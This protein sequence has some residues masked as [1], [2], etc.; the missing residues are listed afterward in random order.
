[1]DSTTG[2]SEW[3]YE[4]VI[5][6][7]ENS[8]DTI[9]MNYVTH[10]SNETENNTWIEYPDETTPLL[11]HFMFANN[12]TRDFTYD[13]KTHNYKTD[14]VN[15][16]YGRADFTD[17]VSG[18]NVNTSTQAQSADPKHTGESQYFYNSA[19]IWSPQHG[20]KIN[21]NVSVTIHTTPLDVIIEG[22]RT[23]GD[24]GNT[25]GYYVVVPYQLPLYDA[26]G[27]EKRD[28]E[29][30]IL[31]GDP[32]WAYYKVVQDGVSTSATPYTLMDANDWKYG[33]KDYRTGKDAE[34]NVIPKEGDLKALCDAKATYM[35]TYKG[36]AGLEAT[37][38]NEA[39]QTVIQALRV[40]KEDPTKDNAIVYTSGGTALT[41][42]ITKN[43]TSVPAKYPRGDQSLEA[44]TYNVVGIAYDDKGMITN[45]NTANIGGIDNDHNNYKI[46]YAGG[47]TVNKADLFYT[48]D[49]TKVY[50]DANGSGTNVYKL[51]GTDANSENTSVTGYLKSFDSGKLTVDTNNVITAGTGVT[52]NGL[53][54]TGPMTMS[55]TVPE[56]TYNI[57]QNGEQAIT[58]A[59][60]SDSYYQ[61]LVNPAD[62]TLKTY[63]VTKFANG[64][65]SIAAANNANATYINNNYNMVW[66]SNDS[67]A[68]TDAARTTTSSTGAVGGATILKSG[69]GTGYAGAG[70]AITA[71]ASSEL[72]TP[73]EL[74]VTVT[75]TRKYGDLMVKDVYNTGAT[76]VF[77]IT[78]AGTTAT[79]SG[80][81]AGDTINGI[82]DATKMNPIIDGIEALTG[83]HP[84]DQINEATHVGTYN[85]I[86][87]TVQTAS[88]IDVATQNT[89]TKHFDILNTN[90]Y[91]Y[92]I[93]NGAHAETITPETVTVTTTGER[94]YGDANTT[95]TNLTFTAPTLET[96]DQAKWT[97][98]ISDELKNNVQNRTVIADHAGVY[99]T[100]GSAN[101][102]YAADGALYYSD[103]QKTDAANA[104]GNDYVIDYQDAYTIKKAPLTVTVTG[105]RYYG[106]NMNAAGAYTTSSGT[107]P[108]PDTLTKQLYNVDVV[109]IKNVNGDTA[110]NI[111]NTA[112]MKTKLGTVDNGVG[113]ATT[114]GSKTHIGEYTGSTT[115]KFTLDNVNADPKETST[116][117]ILSSGDYYV[118]ANGANSLTIVK[119]PLTLTT[120]GGKVYD[121]TSTDPTAASAYD[122]NTTATG[123]NWN[124]GLATGDE[125]LINKTAWIGLINHKNTATEVGTYGTN[126]TNDKTGYLTYN[127][128]N[129]GTIEAALPDYDVHY[130]DKYTITGAPVTIYYEGNRTYGANG[131]VTNTAFTETGIMES[132][133]AA[134]WTAHEQTWKGQYDDVT[135]A[136][137]HHGVY[138]TEGTSGNAYVTGAMTLAAGEKTDLEAILSNYIV[139]YKDKLTINPKDVTLHT[140][141][142]RTYGDANSTINYGLIVDK[143]AALANQRDKDL[144]ANYQ[145]TLKNAIQVDSSITERSHAGTYGTDGTLSGNNAVLT[146]TDDQKNA[147][148]AQLNGDY[149]IHYTDKL[150]IDKRNATITQNAT[151]D[152]GTGAEHTAYDAMILDNVK[153]FDADAFTSGK[154]ITNTSDRAT[155]VGTY[156]NSLM[157]VTYGGVPAAE[158]YNITTNAV[159]KVVPADFTYTADHTSYWQYQHIPAQTGKVTNSYGEDV[160]DLVGTLTWPTP[161]DGKVVGIFPIWG[162]GSNDGTGNYNPIQALGNPTAL[163]VKKV[164]KNDQTDS[165]LNENLEGAWQSFRRPLLDIMYLKIKDTG[166]K[167]WDNGV[168]VTANPYVPAAGKDNY[169]MITFNGEV[170]K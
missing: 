43:D 54:G 129:K 107:I 114:V 16:I 161:A 53:V 121:T 153:D 72:I 52:T 91:N 132:E 101:N 136:D 86:G 50:G 49:G 134:L 25:T 20:Y 124:K 9:T 139:T 116:N 159:L 42:I 144:L 67:T 95:T 64:T 93:K 65:M 164:P 60:D 46:T 11:Q 47:L 19:A 24:A 78:G 106:D 29:G 61:V 55:G 165:A 168:F 119:R 152:Y 80:L 110:A 14:D 44:G 156:T 33:G 100:N 28:A 30:N 142:T 69:D 56:A 77:N 35:A 122:I 38:L 15:N 133:K 4:K 92:I 36:V 90:N 102:K 118:N 104:L 98:T 87:N 111:L 31:L 8:T 10:A 7:A 158:N 103:A 170:L 150:T 73:A 147:T 41:Q 59:K 94:V 79:G 155:N 157:T 74:Q 1:V 112:N 163:E 12:I 120:T 83:N 40:D 167:S 130:A 71:A 99:G 75:G 23:Y 149:N 115:V 151:K 6:H 148:S 68:S 141:G 117:T 123:D 13:A 84:D 145:T 34:G 125:T 27:F 81:K 82:V 85:L 128:T 18:K 48:Y 108:A 45:M 126:G 37:K 105:E 5:F 169:G 26:N 63:K 154:T 96:W 135:A 143:N 138:G 62:G 127:D 70:T 17:G 2:S 131:T 51:V 166:F 160:S 97:T 140:T 22:T 58:Q 88:N 89:T 21:A 32:Q 57:A 109:G 39:V 162:R 76:N 66:R 3:V 137:T 113:D 146:Y